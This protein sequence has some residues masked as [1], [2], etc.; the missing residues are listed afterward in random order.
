MKRNEKEQAVAEV[1]EL[2]SNSTSLFFTDFVGM[3]VAESNELRREFQKNGVKYRVV[4]NTLIKKA[5]Q[6]LSSDD[7]SYKYLVGQTGI[8]FGVEDPIAP[9][10]VLKKFFD[11]IQKPSTKAFVVDKQVFEG[12]RLNEFALMPSK[13]EMIASILGS[14]QSPISGIAGSVSAVM[15]DLVSVLDAVEKKLPA[16]AS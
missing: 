13:P 8:A 14:L 10:K 2:M 7:K 9:A 6:T 4:K 11:K 12:K 16:Q 5:M 1:A 15:R 3:T